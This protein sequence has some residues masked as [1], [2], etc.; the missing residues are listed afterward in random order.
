MKPL[1]APPPPPP[2]P[3]P[4]CWWYATCPTTFC[5]VAAL[6]SLL[7]ADLD[8]HHLD[9]LGFHTPG[10]VP[11]TWQ[12][13]HSQRSLDFPIPGCSPPPGEMSKFDQPF[14]TS[15]DW[16]QGSEIGSKQHSFSLQRQS[17][18][19]RL[20]LSLSLLLSL[21][22]SLSLLGLGTDAGTRSRM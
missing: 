10:A 11:A 5:T 21:S 19:V 9:H 15:L 22:I 18:Y 13:S 3:C 12:V 4:S 20:S 14:F 8:P 16:T 6:S 2:Y 17:G 7:L 1:P